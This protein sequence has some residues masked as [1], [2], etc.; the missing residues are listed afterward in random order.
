MCAI[1]GSDLISDLK[2]VV[3]E[4]GGAEPNDRNQRLLVLIPIR[5]HTFQLIIIYNLNKGQSVHNS[6][7]S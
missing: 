7:S 3:N 2:G 4:K 5:V 1:R 6:N